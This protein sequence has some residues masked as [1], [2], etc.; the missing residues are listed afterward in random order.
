MF[1]LIYAS[2]SS[3]CF[4]SLVTFSPQTA[5]AA[6][7]EAP[8]PVLLRPDFRFVETIDMK[9]LDIESAI[10]NMQRP[11]KF[12][13]ITLA[14][15]FDGIR[16]MLSLWILKEP[17]IVNNPIAICAFSVIALIIGFAEYSTHYH[18]MSRELF[19]RNV[20]DIFHFSENIECLMPCVE[21]FYNKTQESE[22]EPEDIRSF[23]K[24]QL[25]NNFQRVDVQRLQDNIRHLINNI[26]AYHNFLINNII[27]GQQEREKW[28]RSQHALQTFSITSD[29]LISLGAASS[30][31]AANGYAFTASGTAI[32][33]LSGIK[34]LST[35]LE[36]NRI[37]SG[38]QRMF[39]E[40]AL[41][42]LENHLKFKS[43]QFLRWSGLN[44]VLDKGR[45]SLLQFEEQYQHALKEYRQRFWMTMGLKHI[46]SSLKQKLSKTPQ[47]DAS[48]RA[49]FGGSI[50]DSQ[51]LQNIIAQFLS[52]LEEEQKERN[53]VDGKKVKERMDALHK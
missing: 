15:S 44:E 4:P 46:T 1:I 48:I 39:G 14:R 19:L 38:K 6:A 52:A 8:D 43:P 47:P 53:A 3:G 34:G 40:M 37:A 32:A 51:K 29:A 13:R 24:E 9:M 26:V 7:R 45:E 50:S 33:G 20:R 36:S 17:D 2:E 5:A 27:L 41:L 10:E 16:S 18:E 21:S 23:L 49:P 35:L 30:M 31:V 25:D 12:W 11:D 22:R 28:L 42:R